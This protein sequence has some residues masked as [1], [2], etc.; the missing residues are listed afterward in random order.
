[1][2]NIVIVFLYTICADVFPDEVGAYREE[3][4]G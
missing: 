1:M 2:F 4:E 3:G